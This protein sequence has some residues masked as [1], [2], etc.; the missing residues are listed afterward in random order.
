MRIALALMLSSGLAQAQNARV[1]VQN[2]EHPA[3][4]MDWNTFGAGAAISG[5]RAGSAPRPARRTWSATAG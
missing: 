2:L 1:Q 5:D 3:G 4:P